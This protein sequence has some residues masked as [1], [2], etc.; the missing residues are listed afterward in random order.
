M[1]NVLAPRFCIPAA[2]LPSYGRDVDLG[3]QGLVINGTQSYGTAPDTR[4]DVAKFLD[5]TMGISIFSV[6]AVV[7]AVLLCCCLWNFC[8]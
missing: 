6:L 7:G 8:R 2:S 4:S 5:S 1:Q 3:S